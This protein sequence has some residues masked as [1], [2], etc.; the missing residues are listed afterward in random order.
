MIFLQFKGIIYY[1]TNLPKKRIIMSKFN[2]KMPLSDIHNNLNLSFENK[3]SSFLKLLE[4]HIHFESFISFFV[5]QNVLGI[6]SDIMLINILNLSN[7]LHNFCRFHKVPDA[8][9]LSR[10][11][12][13]YHANLVDITEPIYRK[14]NEKKAKYLIY[15]TSGIELPVK[16]NN[17]KFL[18]TKLNETKKLSSTKKDSSDSTSA[19][20]NVYLLPFMK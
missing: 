17:P 15:D 12:T 10:F 3:R 14:I 20:S 7:E 11:R 13:N 6:P 2:P 9:Q 1:H 19:K 8:S 16:E 5:L 4:K 18:E